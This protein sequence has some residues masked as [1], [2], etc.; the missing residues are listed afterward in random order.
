MLEF[1]K[2][3]LN[4]MARGVQAP[5]RRLRSGTVDARRNDGREVL[6]SQE[7]PKGIAVVALIGNE[8]GR[9]SDVPHHGFGHFNIAHVAG[10]E[11][12]AQRIAMRVGYA[13]DFAREAPARAPERLGLLPPFAPAACWWARTTVA[14]SINHSSSAPRESSLSSRCHSP[15]RLQREKRV[16]TLSHGPNASGRSR[17][18]EP[19]RRRQSIA[20]TMVRFSRAGRALRPRSGGS[21]GE[22]RS[23]IASDNIF[24]GIRSHPLRVR[25]ITM[26]DRGYFENRA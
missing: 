2:Q 3:I 1:A 18:G 10:T 12:E 7:M 20:S 11:Q 4:D 24:R 5:I 8:M 13:M 14:S 15:W 17:Q 22:S 26:L 19:T 16:Y 21:S 25:T 23:H 6:L 9:V